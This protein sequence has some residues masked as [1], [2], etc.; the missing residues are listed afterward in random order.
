MSPKGDRE[1]YNAINDLDHVEWAN[2]PDDLL[3]PGGRKN[4]DKMPARRVHA[5]VYRF[6]MKGGS[7]IT[8]VGS[9]IAAKLENSLIKR[10][11]K[12]HTVTL[13]VKYF[14]FQSVTRS[15][16]VDAPVDNSTIIMKHIKPLLSKTEAGEKKVRLLGISISNFGDE[17]NGNK[18][19]R[20]LPLPLIFAG[21]EIV[22]TDH[23]VW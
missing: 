23:S 1:T 8:L 20:Q 7:N 14:D 15:V 18:K 21:S 13:K 11:A 17:K 4:I 22:T 9:V 3:L 10:Q 5:K 2:L 16:T 19:Y 6:W 12:G